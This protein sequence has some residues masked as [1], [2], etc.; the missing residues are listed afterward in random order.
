MTESLQRLKFFCQVHQE[1]CVTQR[2]TP[3]PMCE[4]GPHSLTEDFLRDKWEYCCACESFFSRDDHQPARSKCP[5][6]ERTILARYL[7]DTCDTLSFETELPPPQRSFAFSPTGLPY[8]S[9]PCCLVRLQSPTVEHNCVNGL[10]APFRTP[11]Q[12]CPFCGESVVKPVA[13]VEVL[14]TRPLTEDLPAKPVLPTPPILFPSSFEKP[15]N[16]YLR[17]LN[18]KAVIAKSVFTQPDALIESNDGQFWL[19]KYKGDDSFIVFPGI[20]SF[21]SAQDFTRFQVAFDCSNPE[22][23]QVVI[24]APAVAYLNPASRIWTITQK[25]RLKVQGEP[26][27]VVSPEPAPYQPT[28]SAEDVPATGNK[29]PLFIGGGFLGVVLIGMLIYVFWSS[30]KRQIISKVKQGQITTPVGNSAYDLFLKSNLSES[31]RADLAKEIGGELNS[32]GEAVITQI[33]RDGFTPT[34]A[35]SESTSR[36]YEW[37]NKLSPQNSHE[38]RQLYFRGRVAFDNKDFNRAENDF[39]RALNLDP[40]LALAANHIGRIYFQRKNYST[41]HIWYQ[42]AIDLAPNWMAPRINLCVLAVSNLKNYYL[43][44]QVCQNV[45]QLDPNKASGYFFLGVSLEGQYR[46]C[47]A[48]RAY[49]TALEKAANSTA[50][51]GFTVDKLQ[52]RLPKLQSQ[53]IY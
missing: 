26:P 51:P 20:P 25:G 17:A 50:D 52:Q 36:I 31:D 11:R 2:A 22:A 1:S 13:P 41:T 24:S 38:S 34:I 9:C 21:G 39:R 16:E 23:G 32:K 45:L 43:G 4:Q 49:Q 33:V 3:L 19:T 8:P 30:P 40:N 53:C 6:C 44:E 28:A 18:G 5:S 14:Q 37:L 29:L 48:V 7:C 12:L 27:R 42:Q 35:E 46:T 15:V 47:E 10:R